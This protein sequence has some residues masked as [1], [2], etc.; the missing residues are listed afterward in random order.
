M[1]LAF[2]LQHQTFL[3]WRGH[4]SGLGIGHSE[5]RERVLKT[6]GAFSVSVLKVETEAFFPPIIPQNIKARVISSKQIGN[7]F[8]RDPEWMF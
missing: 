2:A 4:L 8:F 7:V 1:Y 5:D 6:A 3:L